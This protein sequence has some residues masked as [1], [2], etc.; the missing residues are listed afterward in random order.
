MCTQAVQ[1][2]T[3]FFTHLTTREVTP[4]E[5]ETIINAG[6]LP[7][8]RDIIASFLSLK[9]FKGHTVKIDVLDQEIEIYQS[10]KLRNKQ[11][12]HFVHTF[13]QFCEGN[14][15]ILFVKYCK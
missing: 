10:F 11:L 4:F 7:K 9:I 15:T 3:Q 6:E 12:Y 1:H 8:T 13:S 5:L 14:L 2:L